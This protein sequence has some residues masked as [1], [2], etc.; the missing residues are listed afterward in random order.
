MVV[1]AQD[2]PDL[3]L[4][5]IEEWKPGQFF[6]GLAEFTQPMTEIA[7][8][9]GGLEPRFDSD[10]LPKAALWWVTTDMARLVELSSQ[11]LPPTT[12]TDDLLVDRYGFA[13]FETPLQGLDAGVGNQSLDEPLEVN[14]MLWGPVPIE[15]AKDGAIGIALYGY[16]PVSYSQSAWVPLGRTDWL[17]GTDTE[18][19]PHE[20]LRTHDQRVA[21]MA[22]DRRWLAALH[23]MAAEK[24]VAQVEQATIPRAAVRR[25]KR[26]NV[27]ADVRLI[28]LRA[29]GRTSEKGEEGSEGR[30]VDWQ[31][32]WIVGGE[33]GGF[34]RQTPYGP[35]RSLRR[36]QWIMPFVKGPE[37]K[38]LRVRDSVKVVRGNQ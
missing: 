3:R 13:V 6:H 18:E 28:D 22:E 24:R 12:L 15:E 23:L 31:Y 14:A 16:R 26:A 27:P 17:V 19:V 30:H 9:F 5:F 38:P 11:S 20:T 37:G 21:S 4:H 29:P 7:P 36:P 34:W 2:L 1:R 33:T 32:R 25:S 10:V 8:G 35:G